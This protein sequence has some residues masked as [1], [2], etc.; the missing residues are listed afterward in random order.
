MK[1]FRKIE[2]ICLL[3]ILGYSP[4]FSL[5]LCV[6]KTKLCVSIINVPKCD[7]KKTYN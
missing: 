7:Q 3:S 1:K 2:T 5:K 6:L 4:F